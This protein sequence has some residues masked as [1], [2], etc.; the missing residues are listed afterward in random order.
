MLGIV[1]AYLKRS[2]V[3]AALPTLHKSFSSPKSTEKDTSRK[4]DQEVSMTEGKHE[5]V[6]I[7]S[8]SANSR[9]KDDSRYVYVSELPSNHLLKSCSHS[10]PAYE[11]EFPDMSEQLPPAYTASAYMR[12]LREGDPQEKI[13]VPMIHSVQKHGIGDYLPWGSAGK[14]KRRTVVIRQMTRDTYLRHYAKDDGGNYVGTEKMYPDAGLVLVPSKR[15]ED[16]V[17]QQV[18]FYFGG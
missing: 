1:T 11:S 16:D 6:D 5:Y 17:L 14:V 7:A 3:H 15:T 13:D 4:A 18:S 8:Q 2:K 10:P 9:S 12:S